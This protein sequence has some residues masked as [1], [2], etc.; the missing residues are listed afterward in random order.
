[1]DRNATLFRFRRNERLN[2]RVR[3]TSLSDWRTPIG[4]ADVKM[5]L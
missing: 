3:R 5:R 1:M 4:K 2:L